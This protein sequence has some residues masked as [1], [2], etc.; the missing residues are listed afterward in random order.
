MHAGIRFLSAQNVYQNEIYHQLMRVYREGVVN[1][2]NMMKWWQMFKVGRKMEL[3]VNR[4]FT[5]YKIHEKCPDIYRKQEFHFLQNSWEMSWHF[6]FADLRNCYRAYHYKFIALTCLLL[7]SSSMASIL[8]K[9]FSGD[10]PKQ[11]H[12]SVNEKTEEN[13]HEF[14]WWWNVCLSW[15]VDQSYFSSPQ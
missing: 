12:E 15:C 8:H 1:K 10:T 2:S 4:N 3:I 6:S 7:W 5:S 9:Y 13:Y 14:H 11:F